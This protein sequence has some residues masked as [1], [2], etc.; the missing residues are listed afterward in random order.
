[1]TGRLRRGLCVGLVAGLRLQVAE[2]PLERLL[3]RAMVLPVG[4]VGDEVLTDLARAV[5]P[6][7]GIEHLPLSNAS[8][9]T[10]TIEMGNNICRF[11]CCSRARA[12]AIS[13]FTQLLFMLASDRISSS[14]S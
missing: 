10:S 12:F 1:M 3:A 9:G 14:L 4:E 7:V 8:N 5:D 6:G 2:Q 11:C 13:V